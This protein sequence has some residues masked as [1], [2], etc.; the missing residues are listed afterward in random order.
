MPF[1]K[2]R[3]SSCRREYRCL[4]NLPM[5][6]IAIKISGLLNLP[7]CQDLRSGVVAPSHNFFSNWVKLL[8]T[9][10]C[11]VSKRLSERMLDLAVD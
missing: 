7:R 6:I 2:T 10:L 1:S 5:I 8:V 3:V 4:R 11:T 9:G